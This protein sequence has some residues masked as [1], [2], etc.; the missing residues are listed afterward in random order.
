MPLMSPLKMA[1]C[2][3][4]RTCLTNHK[5]SQDWFD[6]DCSTNSRNVRKL[7]RK[8]RRTLNADDRNAFCITR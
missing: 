6:F 7:L 3:K 1:E 8:F 5:Q 4:K 2:V